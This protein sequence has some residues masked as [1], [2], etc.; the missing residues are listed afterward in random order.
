MAERR[1]DGGG[2][3]RC[4]AADQAAETVA[5]VVKRPFA[6]PGVAVGQNLSEALGQAEPDQRLSGAFSGLGGSKGR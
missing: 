2:D 6:C 5:A 3:G 1:G 4:R